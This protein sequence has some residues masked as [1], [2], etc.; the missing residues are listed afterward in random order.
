MLLKFQ[1]LFLLK[2]SSP[3]QGLL[4]ITTT[5][6]NRPKEDSNVK[7]L[8][9]SPIDGVEFMAWSPED[10]HMLKQSVQRHKVNVT[11]NK[12]F[13]LWRALARDNPRLSDFPLD[14]L[15]K[16]YRQT[17]SEPTTLATNDQ[18]IQDDSFLSGPSFVKP[19][20]VPSP[21]LSPENA[22]QFEILPY[23]DSYR[24]GDSGDVLIGALSYGNGTV[25]SGEHTTGRLHSNALETLPKGYVGTIQR[26]LSSDN[27]VVQFYELG[28]PLQQTTMLRISSV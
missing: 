1:L 15:V 18:K 7:T 4:S 14:F 6:P 23:L 19:K 5:H 11:A 3:K 20:T 2:T 24:F 17:V 16:E 10:S 9:T 25:V 22:L 26:T 27:G 12:S 28:E 13:V 8:S 21:S